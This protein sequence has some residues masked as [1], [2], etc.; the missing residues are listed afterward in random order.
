M[1]WFFRIPPDQREQAMI[2]DGLLTVS[3]AD[4]D[5]LLTELPIQIVNSKAG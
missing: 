5:E 3:D 4:S 1:D 2:C